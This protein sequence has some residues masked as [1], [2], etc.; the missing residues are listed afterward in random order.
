M[1]VIVYDQNNHIIYTFNDCVSPN[2]DINIAIKNI[3][4]NKLSNGDRVNDHLYITKKE[5][6]WVYHLFFNDIR[7]TK[8][9]RYRAK[10]IIKGIDSFSKIGEKN[11]DISKSITDTI[12][13][14]TKNIIHYLTNN[15]KKIINYEELC[16]KENKIEYIYDL[17]K[18]D[19][20]K[21]SREILNISKSLEQVSFEYNIVDYLQPGVEILESDK[22]RVKIH[23]LIVQAFYI[24]EQDFISKNIKVNIQQDYSEIRG[25]FFTLRSAFAL[26]M[27]NCLKYCMKNCDID[28][29]INYLNDL[30]KID[31]RMTSVYNTDD[32][33]EKMFLAY[34]RGKEAKSMGSGNGLGLYVVKQLLHLNDIE[35]WFKRI[36]DDI[37]NEKGKK[38]SYNVFIINIPVSILNNPI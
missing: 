6:Q 3:K 4:E 35:I 13:H 16:I 28:V 20:M 25:N 33:I 37:I 2:L 5:S 23:S 24:Y 15:V 12:S 17:I 30:I 18:N 32:E 9:G 11:N 19:L 22:T 36:N 7:N 8:E 1:I 34:E 21:Y 38:Y 27:E 29:E 14:N 10:I 26:I 31:I